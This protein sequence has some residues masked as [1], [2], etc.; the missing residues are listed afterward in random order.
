MIL[1]IHISIIYII[2][3]FFFFFL[4]NLIFKHNLFIQHLETE[5]IDRLPT[6]DLL[7]LNTDQTIE[8][9]IF[10]TKFFAVNVHATTINNINFKNDLATISKE[11]I[12]KSMSIVYLKKKKFGKFFRYINNINIFQLQ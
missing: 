4:G 5:L 7:T 11:T 2:I 8:S 6:K 1:K 10:I 3:Q 9:D 12:I